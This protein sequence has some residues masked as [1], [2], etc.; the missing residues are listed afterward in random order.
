MKIIFILWVYLWI[1]QGKRIKIDFAK[2][3]VFSPQSYGQ[4]PQGSRFYPFGGVGQRPG[5]EKPGFGRI[6]VANSF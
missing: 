2:I 1:L 5:E 3:K 6:F 4:L